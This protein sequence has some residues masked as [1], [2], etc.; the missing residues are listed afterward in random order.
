MDLLGDWWTP[1]VLREA[2][3]GFRRFDEFQ[4]ELASPVTRWPPGCAAWWAR[5]SW[6]GSCTSRNRRVMSMC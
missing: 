6:R 4:R 1:L 3:Y 5:D 2:F